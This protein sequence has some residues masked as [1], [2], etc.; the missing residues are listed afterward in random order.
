MVVVAAPMVV[1]AVPMVVMFVVVAVVAVLVVVVAE[2]VVASVVVVVIV[3]KRPL[4]NAG[5]G[6]ELSHHETSIITGAMDLTQRTA[7]DA[8]TPIPE[9][10]S[11]DINSKLDMV[12]ESWPLYEILNQFQKGR[13]HMAVVLKSNKDTQSTTAHAVGAPSFLNIITPKISNQ[14]RVAVESDSSFVLEISHRSS[15]HESTLNSSDAE[16]HSPTIKNVMELDSEVRQESNQWEQE[17]GYFSQEQIESLPDVIDEEVIGI[18]TMEDV[19]EELLQRDILD[20]TDEYV[21]VQK[22]I[23]INLLQSLRSQSRS[24]RRASGSGHR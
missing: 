9:T 14:A 8:M 11:L 16:F 1:V 13:S 2:L 15:V 3:A 4:S 7:K 20:E 10:F 23:R 17:N 12:Y 18:I 24:S 19:M 21:H 22:N 5:K 6:G